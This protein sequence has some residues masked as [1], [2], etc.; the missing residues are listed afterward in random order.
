MEPGC[1][2][3]PTLSSQKSFCRTDF[4]NPDYSAAQPLL[5]PNWFLVYR[6]RKPTLSVTAS[7]RADA[8]GMTVCKR[9]TCRQTYAIPIV[10]HDGSHVLYLMLRLQQRLPKLQPIPIQDVQHSRPLA[11]RSRSSQVSVSFDYRL[12]GRT[13]AVPMWI[14]GTGVDRLPEVSASD[15]QLPI[16][17][18]VEAVG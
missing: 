12:G 4:P 9:P 5:Q 7:P 2:K 15:H 17:L 3:L 10:D 14:W 8:V 6:L 16:R 13:E 11:R 18:V 1:A